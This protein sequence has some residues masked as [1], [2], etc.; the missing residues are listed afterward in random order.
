[1]KAKGLAKPSEAG[2][3]VSPCGPKTSQNESAS[4]TGHP[5]GKAID[6]RPFCKPV[7]SA[8]FN[9]S[10]CTTQLD[11][12]STPT[13][14]T[15]SDW[16]SSFSAHIFMRQAETSRGKNCAPSSFPYFMSGP[17]G[18]IEGAWDL[19]GCGIWLRA[20]CA[21]L[22]FQKIDLLS[23]CSEPKSALPEQTKH[24]EAPLA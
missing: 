2:T 8:L 17:V 6:L 9:F 3:R 10:W 11:V 22:P 21:I 12:Y 23:V 4:P 20:R 19:T 1:M 24:C 13:L 14:D 16:K 15:T 7:F 18:T 5:S